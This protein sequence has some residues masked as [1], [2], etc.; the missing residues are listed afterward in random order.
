M[1]T[2]GATTIQLT[3]EGESALAR[4]YES[5]GPERLAASLLRFF[6]RTAQI[7]ASKVVARFLRRDAPESRVDFHK[8]D[9]ARSIIGRA[10][11][12]NG[13]PAMR[14]GALRG[15]AIR[16][17]AVQEFGTHG[18]NPESPIPTIVPREAKALAIPQGPALYGSGA[19]KYNKPREY[20]EPLEFMWI[21]RGKVIGR[22]VT[23]VELER[24]RKL[25]KRDHRGLDYKAMET[26]YL[27]LK[28]VDIAPK[29][30]LRDG[31]MEEMPLLASDLSEF[32][33]Q[34]AF[35]FPP[36][37]GGPALRGVQ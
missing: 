29:Y 4:L 30:F 15:P 1:V 35:G 2:A 33:M 12:I 34:K 18:K 6:D 13:V 36:G 32:F 28:S 19:V 11:L 3:P 37:A 21:G 24:E 5:L 7:I 20:P 26:V 16:Y 14:V 31:F 22:L 8:G 17:A 9:L 23:L 10:E 27:L 25:A